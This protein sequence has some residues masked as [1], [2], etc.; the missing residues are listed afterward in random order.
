MCILWKK[1]LIVYAEV[2]SHPP[3]EKMKNTHGIK[4]KKKNFEFSF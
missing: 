2:A 3:P 4:Q 1:R